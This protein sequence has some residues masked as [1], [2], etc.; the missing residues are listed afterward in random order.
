MVIVVDDDP[1]LLRALEFSL[2]LE[3]FRVRAYGSGID[4][5][6]DAVAIEDACLVLDYRLPGLD[7]LALLYRLRQRGWRGP[8]VLMTSHPTARLRAAAAAAAGIIE[9][10][11]VSDDL[12]DWIRAASRPSGSSPPASISG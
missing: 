12:L 2:G 9:K 7:G 5:L 3:G 6:A 1:A 8:A 4:L 10:P 11:L